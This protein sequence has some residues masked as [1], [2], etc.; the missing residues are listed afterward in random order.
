[1]SPKTGRPKIDNPRK[2]NTRIRMT[3][4]EVKMLDYCSKQTGK[5][6]TDVVIEGIQRIY[7]E[8]QDEKK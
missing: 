5:T 6:K 3:D 1:M 4:D 7:N 8:L 2:N